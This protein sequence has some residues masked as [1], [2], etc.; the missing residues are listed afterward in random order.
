MPGASFTDAVDN[1]TARLAGALAD[2]EDPEM[3]CIRALADVV[4]DHI[5]NDDIAIL[6]THIDR[7]TSA[8]E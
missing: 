2:K 5:A 1:N 8:P 7:P 4:V 6:V 3:C